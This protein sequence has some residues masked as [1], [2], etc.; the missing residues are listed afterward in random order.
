VGIAVDLEAWSHVK[1]QYPQ[2]GFKQAHSYCLERILRR[3]ID[4]LHDAGI[5][6]ELQIVF[7]RD[8]EFSSHRIQL[9]V[10]VTNHDPRANALISA[11]TFARMERFP[12]L[13]CAD[14]LAWE[15]RKA[16]IRESAGHKTTKRWQQLF[17]Q[18]PDYHLQYIGE[19]WDQ[20]EFD[21]YVPAALRDLGLLPKT[22]ALIPDGSPP[23]S[24]EGSAS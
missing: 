12:G 18:M 24:S 17:T 11:I 2:A 7:D 21:K 13:Q 9:Y 3:V 20:S 14:L 22:D 4:R 23:A 19:F 10:E 8:P 5:R 1:K 6:D 15:T 16:I